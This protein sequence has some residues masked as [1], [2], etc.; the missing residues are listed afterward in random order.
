M[1]TSN[2]SE[3]LGEFLLKGWCMLADTCPSC[4]LLPLMKKDN[5]CICVQCHNLSYNTSSE[6]IHQE[7][8][9][10]VVV[11]DEQQE[12]FVRLPSPL[13]SSASSS[14]SSLTKTTRTA[15]E[16][17]LLK[18]EMATIEETISAMMTCL[19]NSNISYFIG[20]W[21]H[22]KALASTF[23]LPLHLFKKSLISI[24]LKLSS[25]LKMMPHLLPTY[26]DIKDSYSNNINK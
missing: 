5:E 7:D 3:R 26:K 19:I 13:P 2:P 16:Q 18:V 15:E 20:E 1:T 24:L 14:A 17:G 9:F 23:D 11:V 12:P 4:R 8:S 6:V 10:D 21:D 22:C 25:S